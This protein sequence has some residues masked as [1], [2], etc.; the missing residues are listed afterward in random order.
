MYLSIY[1]IKH[2]MKIQ[3]DISRDFKEKKTSKVI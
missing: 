2:H 3:R 1:L